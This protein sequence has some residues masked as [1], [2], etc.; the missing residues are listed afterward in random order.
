MR[1]LQ[2]ARERHRDESVSE[3]LTCLHFQRG[4]CRYGSNCAWRHAV[5]LE[6]EVTADAGNYA[7]LTE[8]R[9]MYR[10]LE[11][12]L[13]VM[14]AAGAPRDSL[15]DVASELR[16]LQSTLQALQLSTTQSSKRRPKPKNA[17]RASALRRFLL[18]TYGQTTL[19]AGSGVVDIAGGQGAL[20][21]E[22]L[23]LH[24]VPVTVIDPRHEPGERARARF[25]WQ[26]SRAR[27]RS[28]RQQQEES[29]PAPSINGSGTGTGT[30]AG[31]PDDGLP[32][33]ASGAEDPAPRR[34]AHWP[35]Y[36]RDALWRPLADALAEAHVAGSAGGDGVGTGNVAGSAGGDGVG[37][38]K[39]GVDPLAADSPSS[40]ATSPRLAAVAHAL[41]RPPTPPLSARRV[42]KQGGLL[43]RAPHGAAAKDSRGDEARREDGC[44]GSAGAGGAGAGGASASGAGDSHSIGDNRADSVDMGDGESVAG[45]EEGDGSG[46]GGE[47]DS[48]GD[49]DRVDARKDGG[50]SDRVSVAQ[51]ASGRSAGKSGGTRPCPVPP[52]ADEAW[53]VL[54]DCSIVVG[55]HPDHPTESIVDFALATGKPFAVVP[56]CVFA[57]DFPARRDSAGRPVS[58]HAAFVSYL[59]D[60]DPQRIRTATLPFDGKNTVVWSPGRS[61]MDAGTGCEQGPELCSPCNGDG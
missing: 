51:D 24:G 50:H 36:W 34:P 15:A 47:S 23:N 13:N 18:D 56:C 21:F 9:Q 55:M 43:L 16:A 37:T 44:K 61:T 27:A 1:G 20:G 32:V 6:V 22:L 33:G 5:P 4:A 29:G 46:G 10:A 35:V 57:I 54:R 40:I 2:G 17:G 26:W 58:T 3:T 60:K 30:G 49:D 52:S 8:S 59:R 7:A 11:A 14:R 25:E 53:R 42:R 39:N 45:A 19:A 12:R 28:R 48:S 41:G 31:R 38:G